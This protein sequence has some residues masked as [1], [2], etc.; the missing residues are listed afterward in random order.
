MLVDGAKL[1]GAE[2]PVCSSDNQLFH[3]IVLSTAAVAVQ[4]AQL[5]CWKAA[6]DGRAS[7]QLLLVA[8]QL[9]SQLTTMHDI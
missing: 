4:L 7:W 9:L 6:A 2:F 5:S 1:A 8:E 3:A